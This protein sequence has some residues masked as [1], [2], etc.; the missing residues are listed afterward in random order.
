MGAP[1]DTNECATPVEPSGKREI[2]P[3]V[4][5]I[6]FGGKRGFD[7]HRGRAHVVS[8]GAPTHTPTSGPALSFPTPPQRKARASRFW[9]LRSRLG[10]GGARRTS[11]LPT[12]Q[13]CHHGFAGAECRPPKPRSV[14]GRLC[15]GRMQT[16]PETAAPQ[17]GHSTTRISGFKKRESPRQ[18]AFSLNVRLMVRLASYFSTPAMIILD[19]GGRFSQK[20]PGKLHLYKGIANSKGAERHRY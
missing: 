13:V 4:K 15:K 19:P 12:S 7:L 14:P 18:E 20:N 5:R 1:P 10:A 2:Y 8:G 11:K 9:A 6:L 16:C 17:L 3:H